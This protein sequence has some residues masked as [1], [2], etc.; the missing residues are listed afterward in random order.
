MA[1]FDCILGCRWDQQTDY[2]KGSKL[3]TITI[4]FRGILKQ[5]DRSIARGLLVM[6]SFTM[7]SFLL[8]GIAFVMAGMVP[9]LE[10]PSPWF[11]RVALL[12]FE[13]AAPTSFLISAV[14]KYVLWPTALEIGS[15]NT[16][17]FKDPLCLFEH[18]GELRRVI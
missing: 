5:P 12:S 4:Q 14:V 18:N 7:I 10:N 9:L 1:F 16:N 11:L 13:C 8:T 2:D 17:V 6:S 3:K 15:S